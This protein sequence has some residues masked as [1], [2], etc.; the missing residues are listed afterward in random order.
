VRGLSTPFVQLFSIFFKN[1][2][3]HWNF[4]GK[5]FQTCQNKNVFLGFW[6]YTDKVEKNQYKNEKNLLLGLTVFLK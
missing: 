1:R 4:N 2:R 6:G 3:K 5:N